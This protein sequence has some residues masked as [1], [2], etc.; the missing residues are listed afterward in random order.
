MLYGDGVIT[1][2]ISV[3]SAVEG[4]SVATPA[5]HPYVVPL[6]VVILVALLAVQAKGFERVGAAFGP[7]LAIWF[8]VIMVL[9][10]VSLFRTPEALAAFNP[11]AGYEFFQHNGF[12][13]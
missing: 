7:I 12:K 6:T 8:V 5:F 2:A 11:M 1:P 3:L 4:L 13:G 9:G 10:I